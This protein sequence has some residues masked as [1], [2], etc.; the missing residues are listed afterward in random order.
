MWSLLSGTRRGKS[1][2]N[3]WGGAFSARSHM[4][5][6]ILP[7]GKLLCFHVSKDS[8]WGRAISLSP[9]LS[10]R[11]LSAAELQAEF[12]FCSSILD[13]AVC[14]PCYCLLPLGLL[15]QHHIPLAG[16]AG[17]RTGWLSQC[18]RALQSPNRKWTSVC[19][20]LRKR[21]VCT[22]LCKAGYLC[23]GAH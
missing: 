12:R 10:V 5:V 3:N 1:K 22:C 16:L 17:C 11:R 8:T 4:S 18:K 23:Q 21:E 19:R 9:P 13:R 20:E 6:K 14:W 7:H 15:P 2:I